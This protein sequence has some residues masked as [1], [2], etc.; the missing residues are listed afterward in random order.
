MNKTPLYTINGPLGAGKTTLLK[1]L[2]SLPAFTHARLIENEFAN[3]SV[4]SEQLHE[5]KE[6]VVTI[7][8]ECICCSTGD[9]LV[10]ALA[11]FASSSQPVIIEA[12]GMADSL[13]LFEV[14]AAKGVFDTYELHC[15]FFVYDA[16]ELISHPELPPSLQAELLAADIVLMTKCD[17]LT[18]EQIAKAQQLLEAIGVQST[19]YIHDGAI[20]IDTLPSSSHMTDYYL[21]HESHERTIHSATSYTVI[22]T[23]TITCSPSALKTTLL[24]LASS[25]GLRRAKGDFQDSQHQLYHVEMTPTQ[26][27][28]TPTDRLSTGLVLIGRDAHTITPSDLGVTQNDS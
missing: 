19:R 14:L 8:G 26:C 20:S 25:H 15:N 6:S 27:L 9:E 5:H 21:S 24:Q 16:A 10:T 28:V 18:T 7:A 2:I 23:T 1:H 13:Q 12:T 3:I 17:L 11:T 22:D 4:D